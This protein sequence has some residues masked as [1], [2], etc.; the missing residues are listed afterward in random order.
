MRENN[1]FW[2]KASL[3]DIMQEVMSKKVENSQNECE[4]V[5]DIIE[6]ERYYIFIH[7]NVEQKSQ[8]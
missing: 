3:K 6:K 1:S 4:K 2:E 8:I 7:L 5:V